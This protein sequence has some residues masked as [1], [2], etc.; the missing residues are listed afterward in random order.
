MDRPGPQLDAEDEFRYIK[1][2]YPAARKIAM[3]LRQLK[4]FLA[5][6]EAGSILGA[7][8]RLGVAQPSLSR[9]VKLLETELSARLFRRDGRG[10]SLTRDG[11]IFH[12]AIE[13]HVAGLD[14]AKE[15]FL[16][17]RAG[18]DGAIRLGWTGTVSIPYGPKIIAAF[19]RAYPKVEMHARGGSSSQ[20]IDWVANEAI[21]IGVMNSE[22]PASGS[23]AENLGRAP[24]Y[25]V[26]APDPKEKGETV[27]FARAAEYPMFVHSPQ[28]A[29]GRIVRAAARERGIGLDIYAEIDDFV[30]VR[31]IIAQG[32]GAAIVPMGLLVGADGLDLAVRRIV[33]PELWIYF[34]LAISKSG[35]RKPAVQLLADAIRSEYPQR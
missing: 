6:A 23:F 27:T 20:I 33:D 10:V 3:N 32:V 18:T 21:D 1:I 7:A 13:P 16:A 5:I 26:T 30:A 24:L 28:N 19:T 35:R 22:R 15:K 29:L 31:P 2:I 9:D 8:N 34:H 4:H 12:D 17:K 11:Q 25:L 14:R